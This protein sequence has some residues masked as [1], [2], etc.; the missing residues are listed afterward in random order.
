MT[1]ICRSVALQKKQF[2]D[3][4]NDGKIETKINNHNYNFEGKEL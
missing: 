2:L 3:R 1:P 4:L